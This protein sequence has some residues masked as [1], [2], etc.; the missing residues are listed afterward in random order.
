MPRTQLCHHRVG[1]CLVTIPVG[2]GDIS[3]GCAAGFSQRFH[4]NWVRSPLLVLAVLV[5]GVVQ[6]QLGTKSGEEKWSFQ[7]S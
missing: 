7:P 3:S 5:N 4:Q 6:K 2:P 1:G